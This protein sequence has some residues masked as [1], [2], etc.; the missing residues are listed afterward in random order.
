MIA[1]AIPEMLQFTV[2]SN[3]KHLLL[4][5]D[6]IVMLNDELRSEASSFSAEFIP[7]NIGTRCLSRQ[8]GISMTIRMVKLER[9]TLT[10][11]I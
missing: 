7:M 5:L 9:K 8:G 4:I 2:E 10:E 11:S 3:N 1:N 6:Y